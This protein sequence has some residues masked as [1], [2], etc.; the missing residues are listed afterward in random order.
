MSVFTKHKTH[1]E[2]DG[3][4]IEKG[5][6]VAQYTKDM[7]KK[8]FA[9]LDMMHIDS[10]KKFTNKKYSRMDDDLIDSFTE[11]NLHDNIV[12]TA[13]ELI[14]FQI[15][16]QHN[17]VQKNKV[18]GLLLVAYLLAC[19]SILEH[20]YSEYI[21]SMAD[22]QIFGD[23]VYTNKQ[24]CDMEFKLFENTKYFTA[25]KVYNRMFNRKK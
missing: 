8:V 14:Y 4:F 1:P 11:K 2:A 24:L 13:R 22:M 10:I 21:P 3:I 7:D 16:L 25:V 23:N 9:S 20:D 19:K 12:R 18:L 15:R 5:E 17:Y 6:P